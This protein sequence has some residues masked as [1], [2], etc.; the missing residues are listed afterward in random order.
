M[1]TTISAVRASLLTDSHDQPLP[2]PQPIDPVTQEI[3]YGTRVRLE[4]DLDDPKRVLPLGAKVLVTY[5]SEQREYGMLTLF[6]A[7]AGNS[8]AI[9][10]RL[11][12]GG[13]WHGE[14]VEGG[15][16]R[17]PLP[18][19]WPMVPGGRAPAAI[20]ALACLRPGARPRCAATGGATADRAV[21]DTGRCGPADRS[22]GEGPGRQRCAH[23]PALAAHRAG[24]G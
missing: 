6:R 1:P 3:P 24:G 2:S 21:A 14:E 16:P 4:V 12:W 17:F 9:Q 22:V 20:H 18:D 11:P 10:A 19:G 15:P 7:G 5:G 23:R 8:F 13:F